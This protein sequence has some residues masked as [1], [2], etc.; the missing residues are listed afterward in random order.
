MIKLVFKWEK[1]THLHALLCLCLFLSSSAD[2]NPFVLS[3]SFENSENGLRSHIPACLL[4]GK[5]NRFEVATRDL[6][7]LI[8]L[9]THHHLW[10]SAYLGNLTGNYC[11]FSNQIKHLWQ[12]I[13]R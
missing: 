11:R 7:V 6:L 12:S 1:C 10:L 2:A 5:A 9:T 8:G 13:V 4:E 3:I